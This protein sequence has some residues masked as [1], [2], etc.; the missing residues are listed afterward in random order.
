MGACTC[1]LVSGQLFEW[2]TDPTAVPGL[3]REVVKR[4]GIRCEV[5]VGAVALDSPRVGLNPL[6]IM[7]GNRVFRLSDAEVQNLRDYLLAGGFVYADDCGGADYSFRRMLQ[8][9]LPGVELEELPANHPLFS[10]FH[11]IAQVPKVIDLYHGPA[12]LYGLTLDGRLAVVYT[13]DTDLP[14]AWEVYPDGTYVHVIAPEKREQAFQMG[15]NVVLYALS[16]VRNVLPPALPSVVAE[17]SVMPPA[18]EFSP[19]AV[20]VYRMQ[21]QL[22][23]DSIRAMVGDERSVWFGGWSYLPGED[24]GLARYDRETG[25]FSLFMDAEGVL[26]EEINTLALYNGN[27]LI[28]ADTWKFSRG[29][30]VLDPAAHRWKTYTADDGLPH[31]RVID[32]QVQGSKV[33]LACR[34]GLAVWDTQQDTF[35]EVE[36]PGGEQRQFLIS[37]LVSDTAVWVNNFEHVWMHAP[38][39]NSWIAADKLTPLLRGSA[40]ALAAGCGKVYIAPLTPPGSASVVVYNEQRRTFEPFQPAVD[41]KIA[42]ATALATWPPLRRSP[43]AEPGLHE[44]VWVGTAKGDVYCF[45]EQDGGPATMAIQRNLGKGKIVRIH[46][47]GSDVFVSVADFGGVWHYQRGRTK[48]RQLKTRVNVPSDYLLSL[49][50]SGDTLFVGTLAGG[51]WKFVPREERREHPIWQG[52]WYNLNYDLLEDG[53]HTRYLGDRSAIRYSAIYDVTP[54]GK[55]VWM[56]S[57]HGLIVHDPTRTPSGFEIIP[58]HNEPLARLA[59]GERGIYCGRADGGVQVFDP[60][61]NEWRANGWPSHE[62]ITSLAAS[63]AALWVGTDQHLFRLEDAP[64]GLRETGKTAAEVTALLSGPEAMWIGTAKGVYRCASDAFPSLD[65]PAVRIR[66]A[67]S[68]LRWDDPLV[69]ERKR[70]FAANAQGLWRISLTDDGR[71]HDMV[72]FDVSTHAGNYPVTDMA[73]VNQRLYVSTSGGGLLAVDMSGMEDGQAN[74]AT[75][76]E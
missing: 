74:D 31:N 47:T 53:N 4:T 44:E 64:D 20:Q 16:Q 34:S 57:N 48:W 35:R 3:F 46:A 60:V 38:K 58:P 30:S 61:Q 70:L 62:P 14:C 33:W 1:A 76:G 21:R 23:C 26:A 36:V 9:A 72:R 45:S 71:V 69:P 17:P 68:L 40:T 42:A 22:P 52:G 63:G 49:A 11:H 39:V 59:C 50:V 66:S 6:V 29:L 7:T 18:G 65:S 5:G 19:G 25:A 67:T 56:A 55:R 43:D 15:V 37:V 41:T 54:V 2:N 73:E 51:P 12:K 75:A 13:Y 24:E 27:V 10:C 28:G 8:Q 32:I